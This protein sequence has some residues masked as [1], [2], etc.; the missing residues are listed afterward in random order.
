MRCSCS[1]WLAS[2]SACSRDAR[3]CRRR[4]GRKRGRLV[5]QLRITAVHGR[6][7]EVVEVAI[8]VGLPYHHLRTVLRT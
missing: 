3:L 2:C 7:H 5:L 6:E 4:G 8:E 1:C